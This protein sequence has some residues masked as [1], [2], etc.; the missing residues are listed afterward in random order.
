VENAEI[1]KILFFR[2]NTRK[3][4]KF[5]KNII[6]P[7]N[8]LILGDKLKAIESKSATLSLANTEIV[9]KRGDNRRT[10]DVLKEYPSIERVIWID[11]TSSSGS[12]CGLIVE[13]IDDDQYNLLE[14][15]QE[16]NYNIG[17]K[18]IS[19]QEPITKNPVPKK[20]IDLV[21]EDY[22]VMISEEYDN[23]DIE[24]PIPDKKEEKIKVQL[25]LF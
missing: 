11:Q 15:S 2:I 13:K 10:E 18:T 21:V 9:L 5:A 14:F 8:K 16:T 4:S 25:E 7:I 22:I 1:R 24:N 20:W 12:W 23:N 3:N 6:M 19:I 17:E